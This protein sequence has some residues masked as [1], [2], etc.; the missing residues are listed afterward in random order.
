MAAMKKIIVILSLATFLVY[1]C[2]KI[3]PPYVTET[4]RTACDTTFIDNS[5]D[6]VYH[7][8]ILAEEFTGQRCGNCPAAQRTLAT[9]MDANSD[10]IVPITVH[11]GGFAVPEPPD[12]PNDYR[13]APGDEIFNDFNV[14]VTPMAMMNRTYV[15][16]YLVLTKSEWAGAIDYIKNNPTTHKVIISITPSYEAD[17]RKVH[18]VVDSKFLQTQNDSLT[19][20][21]FLLEDSV[22]DKQIDYEATPTLVEQYVHRHVLRASFNGTYGSLLTQGDIQKNQVFR[23]CF[24][25]TLNSAWN[26]AHCHIVAFIFDDDTKTETE[27]HKDII[28]AAEIALIP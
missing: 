14:Q 5:G 27:P 10:L 16:G 7:M 1:A 26:P 25:M 6:T 23:K 8:K 28:Q 24:D 22:I 11:S 21:V 19:L 18:V 15:D 2:D 9:L 3:N 20:S 12:F 4:S 13:T 17:D